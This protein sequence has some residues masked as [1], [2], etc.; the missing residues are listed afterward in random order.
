VTKEAV[1]LLLAI[2]VGGFALVTGLW[3]LSMWLMEQVAL[4]LGDYP[5]KVSLSGQR[6]LRRGLI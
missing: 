1:T 5:L 4:V 6:P 2:A 3:L